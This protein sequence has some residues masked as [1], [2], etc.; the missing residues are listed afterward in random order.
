MKSC[1]IWLWKAKLSHKRKF[2]W[3]NCHPNNRHR[4]PTTHLLPWNAKS[5]NHKFMK[6]SNRM[7]KSDSTSSELVIMFHRNWATFFIPPLWTSPIIVGNF[8]SASSNLFRIYF[9]RTT[10]LVMRIWFYFHIFRNLISAQWALLTELTMTWN[11][12]FRFSREAQEKLFGKVITIYAAS[13]FNTFACLLSRLWQFE[14]FC[15]SPC[16]YRTTP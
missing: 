15:F 12:L 1:F 5:L 13:T 16:A 7:D 10:L 11:S 14:C 9:Q 6:L 4:H 2:S 3:I 8:P